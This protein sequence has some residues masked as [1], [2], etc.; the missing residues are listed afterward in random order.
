MAWRQ[1]RAIALL[2]GM[3]TVLVPAVILVLDGSNVGWGLSGAVAALPVLLGL[4]LIGAGFALWL[5][6]VRLFA[7]VGEGTL[8][9]WDPTR[10]LVARGPYRHL[11][12][13][14][15]T[16]VLAVLAGEAALFG[17]VPL[18][19]WCAAFFLL[20]HAF[21]LLYEEPGLERRFGD[22]YRAYKASVPRW[23]PRIGSR[24]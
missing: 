13:P 4:T 14:M 16:A 21:F 18:L 9:P 24:P 11:R 23:L 20:N 8:A 10:R 15:I 12:N 3:V 17:S 2:P 22:E 5:W 6:T 1:A 7:R 19:I